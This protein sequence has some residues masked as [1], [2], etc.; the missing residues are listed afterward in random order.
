MLELFFK[1]VKSVYKIDKVGVFKLNFILFFSTILE[2]ASIA[3]VFPILGLLANNSQD[4]FFYHFNFLNFENTD[5]V[6]FSLILF[7]FFFIIK[8]FILLF[9]S[10]WKTGFIFN[11]NNIFS[12][13]IFE[14]YLDKDIEFYLKNKPS[15]LLRNSYEEIRKFVSSIDYFFRLLTEILIF[16][17]ITIGLFIFQP[18][19]SLII[20]IFFSLMGFLYIKFTKKPQKDWS[21]K[22]L[23]FSGKVMQILQ[24]SFE[25]IKYIKV[26]NTG[27]IQAQKHFLEIKNLNK[28]SRYSSFFADVPKNFLETAGVIILIVIIFS[29]Y[30]SAKENTGSLIPTLGLFVAA[31]F[32][33]LPGLNRIIGTIQLIYSISASINTVYYD[34]NSKRKSKLNSN[35]LININFSKLIKFKNVHYKYPKSESY[36]FKNL[37][38]DINKNDFVYIKGE[39]GVGKTTLIDLLSGLI[40]PIQGEIII[41]DIKINSEK[42]VRSWQKKIGYIPQTPLMYNGTLVENITYFQNENKINYNK[43]NEVINFAE[44]ENFIK[45]LQGGL[46]YIINERG[47]NLSGGQIQRLAIARSLYLSPEILICDEFTS[48]LDQDT[49]NKILNSL[50]KLKG[51]ITVVFISHNQKLEKISNKIISISKDKNLITNIY[52]K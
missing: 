32:K 50:Q 33:I 28:F 15:S 6:F 18:K 12:K 43:L 2:S 46:S 37:N 38:L 10:W 39:S 22:K 13:Q 44:L 41:D 26:S 23:F 52:V 34:L 3:L 19:I 17:L 9:F 21:S 40:K 5:I 48:S 27:N 31:S 47:S 29:L 8:S 49:E 16:I 25:S 30:D 51:K 45:N 11:L 7:L 14:S 35:N 1:I 20:F 42:N 4:N 24:Q 36:I